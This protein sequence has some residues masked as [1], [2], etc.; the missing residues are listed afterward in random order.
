MC[1]HLASPGGG[2]GGV[3]HA[4]PKELFFSTCLHNWAS[5]ACPYVV[6]C[7]ARAFQQT[8]LRDLRLKK[9]RSQEELSDTQMSEWSTKEIPWKGSGYVYWSAG[10][11]FLWS[12]LVE[13][14]KFLWD[15]WTHFSAWNVLNFKLTS[16]PMHH[17]TSWPRPETSQIV[18]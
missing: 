15:F 7:F 6:M 13:P 9:G 8:G 16:C 11:M 14:L 5:A 3:L 2:V 4:E 12:L 17:Y 10:M 18:D 1:S